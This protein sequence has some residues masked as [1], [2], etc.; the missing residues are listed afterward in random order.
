M[1]DRCEEKVR[2]NENELENSKT[3]V[4]ESEACTEIV[5]KEECNKEAEQEKYEIIIN[6][7]KMN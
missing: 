7:I 2:A 1:K 4:A 3:T 6:A 5:T